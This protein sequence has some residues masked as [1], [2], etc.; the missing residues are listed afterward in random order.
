MFFSMN[1]ANCMDYTDKTFLQ[2]TLNEIGIA[3]FAS[4]S[5]EEALEAFADALA[6]WQDLDN[7]PGVIRSLNNIGCT[8]FALN[9]FDSALEAF[10]ETLEIQRSFLLDNTFGSQEGKS[11]QSND[12]LKQRLVGVSQ[13]LF[14]MAYT[15]KATGSQAT[16]RFLIEE[17]LTMHKT[18][19]GDTEK[20]CEIEDI[21]SVLDSD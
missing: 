1:V 9:E 20:I 3:R 16:T 12:E 21:L 19:S 11:R 14:N 4:G 2:I 13:T 18:L 7:T 8:Y 10:E 6:L 17:V 15:Y 5:L